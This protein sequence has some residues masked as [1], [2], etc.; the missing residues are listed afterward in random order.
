MP[1]LTSATLVLSGTYNASAGFNWA[2]W[3]PGFRSAVQF[4]YDGTNNSGDAGATTDRP[5]I[6]GVVVGRNAGRGHA[7]Y[8]FS[9]FLEENFHI[10][11]R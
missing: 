7:I 9:P 1:S 6:N 11:K 8:D 4:R 10:R 3:H 5:V 2:A